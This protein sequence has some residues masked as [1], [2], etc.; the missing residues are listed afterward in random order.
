MKT[1]LSKIVLFCGGANVEF[2]YANCPNER[3][4]FYPIGLGVIITTLLGFISMMFA[5]HSIFGANTTQDEVYL[6]FFSLFWGFAIFTIDWGLV[7]TMKKPKI[8]DAT[9]EQWFSLVL[10][11]I[12]RLIVA[13]ILSF[14]ISRPLEVKI[15]EQRLTG[16]I[17]IDKKAYIDREDAI[18]AAINEKRFGDKIKGVNN[19]ITGL[20]NIKLKGPQKVSY[21]ANVAKSS[22]CSVDLNKLKVKNEG[23]TQGHYQSLKLIKSQ[24]SSYRYRN[25]DSGYTS[26]ARKARARNRKKN[27]RV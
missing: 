11:L 1:F 5:T 10:T 12:F 14:S 7:K 20:N 4:K 2:L 22:A 9:W 16:Q 25:P 18:N 19:A 24:N 13:I 23:L 27:C 8:Q 3:H 6:V 21:K 26:A 15:Y 17:A